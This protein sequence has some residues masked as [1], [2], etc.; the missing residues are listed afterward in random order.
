MRKIHFRTILIVFPCFFALFFSSCEKP[1]NLSDHENPGLIV[2]AT[3]T[4]DDALSDGSKKEAPLLNPERTYR[5][6]EKVVVRTID[7]TDT[8]VT[9]SNPKIVSVTRRLPEGISYDDVRDY[10]GNYFTEEGEL[11]PDKVFVLVSMTIEND[12]SEIREYYHNGFMIVDASMRI[13][14]LYEFSEM[15]YNSAYNGISKDGYRVF[16]EPGQTLDVSVGYVEDA[17]LL[18]QGRLCYQMNILGS[19]WG[20]EYF[21]GDVFLFDPVIVPEE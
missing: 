9:I 18:K 20:S 14:S 3:E 15:Q 19:G 2:H 1:L 16:L 12:S 4:E 21:G 10:Y 13:I 11:P 8:T 7:G 6:D 17:E 5:P